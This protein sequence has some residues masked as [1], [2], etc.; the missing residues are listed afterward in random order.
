MMRFENEGAALDNFQISSN[1]QIVQFSN[2]SLPLVKRPPILRI[3]IPF[4][5]VDLFGNF[6]SFV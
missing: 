3:F 6:L 1:L 4:L 5:P 2:L